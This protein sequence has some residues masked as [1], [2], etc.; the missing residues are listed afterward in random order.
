MAPH[1]SVF[2]PC[3]SG[4]ALCLA[5]T[6]SRYSRGDQSTAPARGG[7]NTTSV[8]PEFISLSLGNKNK[9]TNKLGFFSPPPK[10]PTHPPAPASAQTS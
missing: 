10:P 3:F 2:I 6:G 4:S 1:N 7:Y 9:Q 8:S 5:P